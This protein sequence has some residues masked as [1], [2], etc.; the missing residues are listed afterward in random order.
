MLGHTTPAVMR[1]RTA[2]EAAGHEPVIFHANGVG[3]PA[4][5]NLVEAGAIAG[6]IDYTLSELANALLDGLHTPPRERLRVA[7]RR[8]VPQ[9]VV[10]GCADF[11]NQGARETVPERFRGRQSYFH[12]PVATLVRLEPDEMAELGRTVAERLNEARGPVRVVA[13]TQ[14]FSLA[15]VEGGDLWYP[16]ADA[17]FL[18]EL[19]AR[20]AAG[21]PARARRHPRQRP[22]LRGP[23]RGALP[24][25]RLGTGGGLSRARRHPPIEDPRAHP[26]GR[27]RVGRR[28]RAR[29]RGLV[30][31]RAPRPRAPRGRRPDRA[32]P[33]RRASRRQPVDAHPGRHRL[34]EAAPAGAAAEGG[35]RRPRGRVR[36]G[37]LD[38]LPRRVDDEPRRSRAAS[39]ATRR[40]RSR[41]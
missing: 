30:D 35:D 26:A 16:E 20:L 7:G 34:G 33:R 21:D 3:G 15:D 31:H 6:V 17:A 23:R 14:G 41:W 40:A 5:E 27:R 4:M 24:R 29:P 9:V 36:R 32:R 2:L 22:R 37:R 38:G 28:A 18:D 12:N 13:P 1:I 19:G 10:P 25:P 11:F 8:G 39:S